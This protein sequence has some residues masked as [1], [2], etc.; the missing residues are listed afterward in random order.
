MAKSTLEKYY[1]SEKFDKERNVTFNFKK[2]NQKISGNFLEFTDA[3]SEFIRVSEKTK[4]ETRVWFHRDGA[5]RGSVGIDKAR[6]IVERI[7]AKN[8]KNQDAIT[9][10]EKE[11]L[12]EKPAPKKTTTTTKKVVEKKAP[13]SLDSEASKATFYVENMSQKTANQVF[14]MDV[15]SKSKYTTVIEKVTP[16]SGEKVVVTYHLEHDGETS[17]AHEYVISGFKK[18]VA[19]AHHTSPAYGRRRQK[20]LFWT[21]FTILS[22]L[23]IVNL[24]LLILR[25]T[26]KI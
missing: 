6:L 16:L 2:A 21:F 22:I 5:Y 24:I 23:I 15:K 18:Q 3:V 9:F 17:K 8:V 4:N 10:I 14:A 25:L 11:N 12:V 1:I 13:F 26:N 20:R 19:C 7:K